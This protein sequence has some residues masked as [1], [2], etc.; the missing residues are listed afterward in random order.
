MMNLTNHVKLQSLFFVT[1]HFQSHIA[2]IFRNRMIIFKTPFSEAR[3]T[4]KCSCS[5]SCKT[6][7]TERQLQDDRISLETKR[8]LFGTIS[9]T[10]KLALILFESLCRK[11]RA[12]Y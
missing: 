11:L 3:G 5:T 12:R 10:A 7:V 6:G 4:L 2:M 9:G 8:V 1:V